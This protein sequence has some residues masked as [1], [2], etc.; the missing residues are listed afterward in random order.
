MIEPALYTFSPYVNHADLTRAF[1]KDI[2]LTL[3]L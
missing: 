3:S 1:Y 2:V